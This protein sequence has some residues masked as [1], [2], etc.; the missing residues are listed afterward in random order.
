MSQQHYE[1]SLVGAKTY[2]TLTTVFQEGQPAV[3]T[4]DVWEMLKQEVNPATGAILFCL[5]EFLPE[6]PVNT[7]PDITSADL[8]S[9]G[10]GEIDTG[11]QSVENTLDILKEPEAGTEELPSGAA[12]DSNPGEVSLAD[13]LQDA[14]TLSDTPTPTDSDIASQTADTGAPTASKKIVIGKGKSVTV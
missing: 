10:L 8:R 9:V 6:K 1:I 11:S 5:T 4:A 2:G 12:D 13:A 14:S 3:V 7:S